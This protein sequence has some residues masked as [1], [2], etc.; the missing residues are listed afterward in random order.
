MPTIMSMQL[1]SLFWL[2]KEIKRK[3]RILIIFIYSG[4]IS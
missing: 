3:E 4:F 2:V 1:P